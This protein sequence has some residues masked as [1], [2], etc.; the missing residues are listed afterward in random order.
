MDKDF[1]SYNSCII[2]PYIISSN[3]GLVKKL[4]KERSKAGQEDDVSLSKD[5][6]ASFSGN[7]EKGVYSIPFGISQSTANCTTVKLYV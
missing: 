3:L 4:E 2:D 6:N 5:A 1:L 7:S